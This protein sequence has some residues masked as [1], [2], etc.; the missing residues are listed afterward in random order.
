M[1]NVYKI[2]V[3]KPEG[4]RLLRRPKCRWDC[5]IREIGWEG[6]D[7]IHLAQGRDH[8]C[9]LVNTGLE[10]MYLAQDRDQWQALINMVMN[11]QVP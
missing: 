1:R 9:A 6:M 7:W 10:W 3:R 11:L 8:K 5:N 2:L 4:K